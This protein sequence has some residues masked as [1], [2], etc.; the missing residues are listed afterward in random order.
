MNEPPKKYLIDKQ[1]VIKSS[2]GKENEKEGSQKMK[3]YPTMFM[4]TKGRKKWKLESP[5]MLLITGM[6]SASSEYLI[7]NKTG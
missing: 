5:R 3:V 7:E 2:E 6:I 1:G 4:K